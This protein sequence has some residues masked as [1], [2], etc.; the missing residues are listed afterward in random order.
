M[1][2]LG[3]RPGLAPAVRP[4]FQALVMII[5][6]WQGDANSGVAVNSGSRGFTGTTIHNPLLVLSWQ[7]F[8]CHIRQYFQCIGMKYRPAV[9]KAHHRAFSYAG[10]GQSTRGF[11]TNDDRLVPTALQPPQFKMSNGADKSHLFAT[12]QQAQERGRLLPPRQ[13]PG[14]LQYGKHAAKIISGIG[15]NPFTLLPYRLAETKGSKNRTC[16]RFFFRH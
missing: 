12:G 8:L 1:N 15:I 5:T 7:Y 13:L 9:A 3:R 14:H 16:R 6:Q 2:E 11:K 10:T 4:A